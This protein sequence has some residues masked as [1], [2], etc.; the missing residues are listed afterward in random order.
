MYHLLR[1]EYTSDELRT[2]RARTVEGSRLNVKVNR[3][4]NQITVNDASVTQPNIQATNGVI[5][6][7]DE[8]LLPP[9]LNLNKLGQ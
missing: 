6:A 3:D 1:G 9:N 8:V 4:T 5:H 2:G 7:V